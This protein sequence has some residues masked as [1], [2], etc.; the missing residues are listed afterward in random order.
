MVC[1]LAKQYRLKF[2][3]STNISSS[4]FQLVHMN[5]WG[6]HKHPT[7]YRKHYFLTIVDDYSRF[8]WVFLLQ[9]KREVGVVLKDFFSMICN[10]FGCSVKTIRSDNGTEFFNSQMN[11]LFSTLGIVHQSSCP[12][13]PQQ[14]GVVERKHK[15]VLEV[16][17]ALKL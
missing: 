14:N 6:P 2:P 4:L 13:T 15:H 7:Y 1:S 9:S 11:A 5:V 8:T 16:G 12:Y 10:Q 17:R 3:S